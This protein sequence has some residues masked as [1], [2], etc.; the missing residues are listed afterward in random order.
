M[1]PPPTTLPPTSLAPPTSLLAPPGTTLPASTPWW[2][3]PDFWQII[4]GVVAVLTL[5]G[6]V[7]LWV[8]RVVRQRRARSVGPRRRLGRGRPALSNDWPPLSPRFTGRVD[9]LHQLHRQLRMARP[10]VL[11]GLGGVGKTQTV[12]AYLKRH[13][14]TYRIIWWVRAEQTATLTQDLARLAG[15]L[16]LPERADPDQTVVVGAVRRWLAANGGWLLV[17]DNATTEHALVELL[18]AQ[19]LRGQVLLTS[20]NQLWPDATTV[21]LDPWTPA[22][23]VDFLQ[24]S[25][26]TAQRSYD[27]EIAAL[28]VELGHLPIALEQASAYLHAVPRPLSEY[29]ALLRA[30]PGRWLDVR[31]LADDERTVAKTWAVALDQLHHTEG[32]DELLTACAFLASDDIPLELFTKGARLLPEPLR[33]VAGDVGGLD[34]AV[35]ALRRYSF[36][37]VTEDALG[38]HRLVQAVCR[39]RLSADQARG[40]AGSAVKL[41][42]Q[43]FPDKAGD[44]RFWPMC[45]LL[46]PHA[47][48]AARH[49][50]QIEAEPLATA[51]LLDQAA[52]YLQS[53]ARLAEAREH[54]EHGLAIAEAAFGPDHPSVAVSRNNLGLVLRD[55]GDLKGAR[56]QLERALAID[57]A[58]LDPD[59]PTVAN[60]RSNLGM[61]LQGLGDLKGA[62]VQLER[63]LAIDEAALDP[64]HPAVAIRRGNLGSVLHSLGDL[65]GARIQQEHALAIQERVLGPDH[66]TVAISR[67]N[68]GGVLLDL[69]DLKGAR[70]Q[71][72][73]ALV[74]IESALGPD[75][76]TVANVRSHLGAVLRDLGH[77]EGAR[78]QLDRALA[79]DEAALGSDHADVANDRA[80][81][82]AVLHELGDVEGARVQLDRALT[83]DEATL[84][85]DH[86]TVA[87]HRNNLALVLR[88]LGDLEGARVQLER[89]LAATEAALGADHPAVANRR[90]NLAS[91]LRD[92]GDLEGAQVQ[93]ERALRIQESA[94]GP[95]HSRAQQIRSSLARVRRTISEQRP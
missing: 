63:A 80:N 14:R 35:I 54:S 1:T 5:V 88:D 75:H 87:G 53:R 27:A 45:E 43:F 11:H 82:G 71:F 30:E 7:A 95:D 85:P 91:V 57:E 77:L 59:H 18:P 56:V 70:V 49:A 8:I 81:L 68:L 67:T 50:A 40:W 89:A 12:L 20:R 31:G 26:P 21:Y 25:L 51:W 29:L 22:E 16:N 76:S 79:I 64:D 74:V 23:S 42:A 3:S 13:Q 47:L 55:L 32:A 34:Q 4:G 37:T 15:P 36:V 60:Y 58:A 33:G 2:V 52:I 78:V 41:I 92:L 93:F 86:P 72:E 73:R 84:G 62:R 90:Y 94:F 10:V 83:I 24:V 9:L 19:P 66:L 39:N 65:E 61:V 17:L 44:V 48:A 38:V 28:A 46:L 69:G 6:A